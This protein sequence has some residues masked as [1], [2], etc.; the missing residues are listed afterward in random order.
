VLLVRFAQKGIDGIGAGENVRRMLEDAKNGVE[1]L[2]TLVAYG[3]PSPSS[4]LA[5]ARRSP[6]CPGTRRPYAGSGCPLV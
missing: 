4:R 6:F 2:T 1:A 3:P 5:P